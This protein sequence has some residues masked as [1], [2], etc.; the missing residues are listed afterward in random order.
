MG[1]VVAKAME[2]VVV[3]APRAT[4]I[5]TRSGIAPCAAALSSVGRGEGGIRRK[6]N[7]S[8][9]LQHGYYCIDLNVTNPLLQRLV[10][11]GGSFGWLLQS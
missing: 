6:K 1:H 10:R 7:D 8:K 2:I 11:C 9:A 4:T 3:V 5:L